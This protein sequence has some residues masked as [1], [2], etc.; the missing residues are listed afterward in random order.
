M[1]TI[2]EVAAAAGVSISTVSRAFNNY[3]DINGKT[4][5][6]ILEAARS[7]DYSPNI[8]ARNLSSKKRLNL[9]LIIS[10]FLNENANVDIL[11]GHMKGA[12]R[13][14]SENNLDLALYITSS[15]EQKRLSYHSFCIEHSLAGAIISGLTTDDNYYQ[16]LSRG[17]PCPSVMMDIELPS[18]DAGIVTSD[19]RS[20]MKDMIAFLISEGHERIAI[21]AGKKSATVTEVRLDGVRDAYAEKDIPLNEND[22]YYAD[23]SRQEAYEITKRLAGENRKY[24]AY[25]CFSDEM[26]FGVI[27][28]LQEEGIKIPQECSVTGFDDVQL[29]GNITPALTTVRQDFEASGYEAAGLLHRILEGKDDGRRMILKCP[30]IIRQSTKACK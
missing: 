4:K 15:E 25:A 11:F 21:I 24:S 14:A 1:A 8:S 17:V 23:F 9:G 26:A 6:R 12:F 18:G 13:Y 20:A 16:E 5:E 19:N 7:L 22:I 29:S 2:K 27:R 30:I 10:G 28:A 3:S